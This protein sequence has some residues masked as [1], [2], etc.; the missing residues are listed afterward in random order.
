MRVL[1]PTNTGKFAIRPSIRMS[2]M[3]RDEVIKAVAAE[4]GPG[5]RVDL[6]NYDK[7]ILLEIYKNTCGMSVVTDYTKFRG[8]NISELH[9]HRED[10][11]G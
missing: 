3:K 9:D 11:S 6:R 2:D 7:L 10:P 8:F 5:H 4:V 1:R